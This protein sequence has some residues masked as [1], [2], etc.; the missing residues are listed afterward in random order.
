VISTPNIQHPESLNDLVARIT[1]VIGRETIPDRVVR[2]SDQLE[3]DRHDPR[4]L[5]RRTAHDNIHPPEKLDTAPANYGSGAYAAASRAEA[6]V[7]WELKRVRQ[8]AA[9][10]FRGSQC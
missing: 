2:T 6:V 10:G 8:C 9:P 7:S 3:P 5:R 1:S 4:A